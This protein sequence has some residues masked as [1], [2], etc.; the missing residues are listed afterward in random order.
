LYEALFPLVRRFCAP[1]IAFLLGAL[2]SGILAR[3]LVYRQQSG[4]IGKLDSRF[5]AN[6]RFW[7]TFTIIGIPAAAL[8]SGLTA[9]IVT[10]IR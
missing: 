4:K 6:S 2:C 1:L 9:G 8:I 10:A 3:F 7:R 5:T